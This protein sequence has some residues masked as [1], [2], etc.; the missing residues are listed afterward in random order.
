MSTDFDT[1]PGGDK[2]GP[3]WRLSSPRYGMGSTVGYD[4]FGVIGIVAM[5]VHATGAPAL[6]AAC[7]GGSA[8]SQWTP[9]NRRPDTFAAASE[10]SQRSGGTMTSGWISLA[11]SKPASSEIIG[12]LVTP[13]GTSTLTVTPVPSRSFAMIALSASS[14]A[15]E[16]P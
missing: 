12:V 4:R 9:R 5:L 2:F 15:L 14:A 8:G 3:G 7:S 6:S 16:G 1:V 10:M 13:P 11:R